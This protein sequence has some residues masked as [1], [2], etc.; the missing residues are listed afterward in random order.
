MPA[1]R[2]DRFGKQAGLAVTYDLAV[3]GAGIIGLAHAHAAA[4]LGKRVVVI[5]RDPR[6]NGA[7]IR[8]FG[9]ITVTG[10]ERGESWGLARRTRDIWADV[11]PQAG[12]AVEQTGL[13][14]TLRRP[15][16]VAV[17][18]AFLQTEM[19]E[20]CS[21]LDAPAFRAR[22]GQ[23]AAPDAL[24]AL[25]SPH[26]IRVESRDALPKLSAWLA[27]SRNVDFMTETAV[28]AVAPPRIETS[29][30][31]VHADAAIVCPGDDFVSL[32]ADRIAA[33]R[34]QKCRLSMLRLASPGFALPAPLMSDLSLARYAGYAALPQADALRRRLAAEQPAHLANGV[35]LI[36]VQSAD[37]SLVVGDSHHYADL[38]DPFA[39][40]EAEACILDEFHRAT[41]LPPP[42]VT[43]RWVGIYPVAEGRT[44]F[45]DSPSSD[46][47]LV[48]VTSGTGA[49]TGFAIAERTI[50]DL[51]GR[52]TGAPA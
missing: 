20:G 47:R 12:I 40:A 51:F 19:G 8:N 34:P 21:F 6:A 50:A 11:A 48:M 26:E 1:Y 3:V 38:P 46:V 36:V 10:Q 2:A 45:I 52:S 35:H 32:F 30:G 22:H 31:T 7:S 33:Y 5:D 23:I 15:E 18:Q 13:I 24:G 25:I 43:E 41:G 49:S 42:P 16:T 37:G 44:F 27:A 39:P 28:H 29:R 4:A 14:V 17:A 9:F